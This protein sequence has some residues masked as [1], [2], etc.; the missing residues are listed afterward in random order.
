MSYAL[1]PGDHIKIYGYAIHG[2]SVLQCTTRLLGHM[3]GHVV[4][5][6]DDGYISVILHDDRLVLA[7]RRQCCRMGRSTRKR[8]VKRVLSDAWIVAGRSKQ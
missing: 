1:Q 5:A 6:L 3:P 8:P 7:H 2:G 4:E